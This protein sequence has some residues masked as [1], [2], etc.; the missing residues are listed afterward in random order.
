M[1]SENMTIKKNEIRLMANKEYKKRKIKRNINAA[2]RYTVLTIG[3]VIML[4]PI[5]WLIG[6]SFKNNS[7]IFSSINFIPKRID[8]T[9]YVKGWKTGTQYTFGRYF[10]NTFKIVIPK[11][12]FTVIS[13][14]L[15]AY[16][17][18]RFKFPGKKIFFSLLIST[19]FLPNIMTRIP[20]YLFWKKLGA[21][22]SVIP[23]VLPSAFGCE[24]FFVF[25]LIQFFRGI[26]KELDEAA[27]VDGCNSFMILTKVILPIL[28]PAIVS[29]TIFQFLW[30]MND[31]QGPLIYISSVKKYPVAIALK[32]AM[33]TT[34][35]SF[36]WNQIIAMSLIGLLPSIILFFSAQKY[37][38]EGIS[39]S[40]LKG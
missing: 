13:S 32:M 25:M 29:V 9:P 39:T 16:G 6:A 4:Y 26:P 24:A 21:L 1:E 27:T 19:L 40:G 30:T 28:K 18:A 5:I 7:E 34:S 22:D 10:L 33:D 31:F 37:F 12:I 20:L 36:E 2:I 3:A 23:L 17:F 38:I 35:G 14:V 8:F 11:V 15:T